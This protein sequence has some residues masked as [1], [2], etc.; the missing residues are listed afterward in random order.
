MVRVRFP[1]MSRKVLN[2]LRRVILQELE[3]PAITTVQ[4]ERNTSYYN[5]EKLVSALSMVPVTGVGRSSI[6]CKGPCIV[7]GKDIQGS[8][9]SP[10][11]IVVAELFEGQE[12]SLALTSRMGKGKDHSMFQ[13]CICYLDPDEP[14]L[15]VEPYLESVEDIV[16][17][18]LATL[19]DMLDDLHSV[20]DSSYRKTK[21]LDMAAKRGKYVIKNNYTTIADVVSRGDYVAPHPLQ[22]EV[23]IYAKKDVILSEKEKAY[24]QL[25]C[26]LENVEYL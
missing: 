12:L 1:K 17:G 20:I 26:A 14:V 13:P 8:F 24:T 22:N 3:H 23:E 7:T 21:K 18:G 10:F 15:V 16:L 4:V 9:E 11:E 5:D 25:E 2:A 6:R 19:M